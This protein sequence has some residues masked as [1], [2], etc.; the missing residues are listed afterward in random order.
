MET[1]NG[2]RRTASLLPVALLILVAFALFARPLLRR[3]V[4]TFRDHSD[5]F[6]PLRLFTGQELRRGLLPLWNPYNASGEPWLANPQT[7]VFY[8]PAWIFVYVPFW[9]AYT[10]LLAAHVALLGCGAFLLFRRFASPSG[11]FLAALSLMLSG[12]AL[13]LLDV[14]NTLMT[15]AWIPLVVWSAVAMAPP[16]ACA[17]LIAM[18]FLAGE[19]FFAALGA[20]FFVCLRRKNI[21]D[22]AAT[23]FALCAIQLLPFLDVLRGSDR[24]GNV[25]ADEILR[26][27]MPIGDWLRVVISPA[28]M[29]GEGHQQFIVVVYAGV[30]ASVLALVAV[31]KAWRR[32]PVRICMAIVLLSMIVAAGT[33]LRPVALILTHLPLAVLRYPAR[34][35]PAAIMAICA[36]AAMGWDAVVKIAP[37][38][39]LPAVVAVVIICDLVPV[40]APLMESGPFEPHPVPYSPALARDTK[41]IRLMSKRFLPRTFDRRAWIAG[42]L[43]LFDRRFDAWTAAPFVSMQYTRAYQEALTRRDRID[44]MSIGYLISDRP[45]PGLSLIARARDVGIYRNRAARL[46]AFWRGDDGRT[47]PPLLLAFTTSAAHVVVDAPSDGTAII[48]QQ[49]RSGWRVMIDG[50][51]AERVGEGLFLAVRV[52]RG[53]HA[54]SWRYLP[55]SFVAGAIVTALGLLRM[56]LSTSFVK[57]DEKNFF[58]AT[59]LTSRGAV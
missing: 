31:V 35:V 1:T 16:M 57:R 18:S 51:P 43:N 8:P 48:T 58:F 40:I 27:S 14:S 38:R 11:A 29:R 10:G 32:V 54:I 22:I 45:L 42:Y 52:P 50:M 12:P 23:S 36:L 4:F 47:V 26:Y 37:W 19:P 56:L 7:A 46:M 44:E 30:V 59:T 21:V 39:M 28:L 41:F 24:A 34:V 55:D 6:Q 25:P 13:S 53:R 3:E 20:L 15:F 49:N 5:Y 9:T 33:Y 2:E 17:A